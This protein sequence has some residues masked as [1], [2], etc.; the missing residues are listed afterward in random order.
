MRL[1]PKKGGAGQ[2]STQ[3]GEVYTDPS[4]EQKATRNAGRIAR[5]EQTIEAM[6]KD[7]PD[8]GNL[9]RELRKRIKIRDIDKED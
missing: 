6:R 9:E 5:L 1:W 2:V 3:G 8:R 4:T 7:H